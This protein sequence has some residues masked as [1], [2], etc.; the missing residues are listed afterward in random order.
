MVPEI[1]C[2][3]GKIFSHFGSFFV[4]LLKN[5]N[6]GKT[7]PGDIVT[8]HLCTTNDNYMMYGSLDIRCNRQSFLWTI[9][10]PFDPPKDLENQNF[11]KMKKKKK[12]K[13]FYKIKK[14][15]KKKEFL[16]ILSFV[17]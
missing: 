16:E 15:K 6:F 17:P 9:F 5:Q 11:D 13:I 14:K 7:K 4:L 1:W 12:K 8:L 10:F 2:S 3:T